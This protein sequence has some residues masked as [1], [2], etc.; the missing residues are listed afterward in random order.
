MSDFRELLY[1]AIIILGILSHYSPAKKVSGIDVDKFLKTVMLSQRFDEIAD[2]IADKAAKRI[3]EIKAFEGTQNET[4][5]NKNELNY[6]VSENKNITIEAALKRVHDKTQ[7]TT[8]KNT[9][10]VKQQVHAANDLSLKFKHFIKSYHGIA[11]TMSKQIQKGV[12][13]FD[14][15]EETTKQEELNIPTTIS[16]EQLQHTN[17]KVETDSNQ[18]EEDISTTTNKE[19][20]TEF[21]L[22]PSNE[23]LDNGTE[24]KQPEDEANGQKRNYNS[25]EDQAD[26]PEIGTDSAELDPDNLDFERNYNAYVEY[27][28]Q[29][30]HNKSKNNKP[31]ATQDSP[32]L[33]EEVTESVYHN[34]STEEII[35]DSKEVTKSQEQNTNTKKTPIVIRKEGNKI[36]TYE[37]SP[38]YDEYHQEL[39]KVLKRSGNQ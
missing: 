1:C 32:S 31:D 10:N 14:G 13:V 12:S 30:K 20:N 33:E 29:Q 21:A 8:I 6:R 22:V 15:S 4:N 3:T 16:N 25:N 37:K 26:G 39:A 27:K 34:Q 28:N 36:Y 7:S 38:D 17:K 19:M 35:N 23:N 9:S 5:P 2:K 11:N 18:I 24:E